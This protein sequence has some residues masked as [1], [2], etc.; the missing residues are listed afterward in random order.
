[1]SLR[2]SV[3]NEFVKYVTSES[4]SVWTARKFAI[5]GPLLAGF[6]PPQRGPARRGRDDS[7]YGFGSNTQTPIRDGRSPYR[8]LL[9]NSSA[10]TARNRPITGPRPK[11]RLFVNAE[12]GLPRQ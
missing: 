3:G 4:P 12:R 5:G 1:M 11:A 2:R 9:A 10:F 6:E 7:R 8:L